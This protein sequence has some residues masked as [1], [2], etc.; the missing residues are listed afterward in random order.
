M[1]KNRLLKYQGKKV[2]IIDDSNKQWDGTVWHV[3]TPED[4]DDRNEYSVDLA[5]DDNGETSLV[6]IYDSEIKT[7]DEISQ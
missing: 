2:R 4:D 5:V 1:K 3:T 6:L 7:I